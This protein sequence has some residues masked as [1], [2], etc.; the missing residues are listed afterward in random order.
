MDEL[1]APRARLRKSGVGHAKVSTHAGRQHAHQC[2]TIDGEASVASKAGAQR[3]P[4]R[5]IKLV[6]G[7]GEQK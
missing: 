2:H 5:R 6:E 1:S 4:R 7:E 3:E